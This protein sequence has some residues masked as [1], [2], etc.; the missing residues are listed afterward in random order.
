MSPLENF[1]YGLLLSM[2]GGGGG[3]G[4]FNEV[5]GLMSIISS[6]SLEGTLSLVAMVE[7]WMVRGPMVHGRCSY[8]CCAVTMKVRLISLIGR[9]LER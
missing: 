6:C 5:V 4:G 8:S 2:D 1:E 7:R 9:W 3:G